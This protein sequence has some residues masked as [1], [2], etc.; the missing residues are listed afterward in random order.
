MYLLVQTR[1]PRRFGRSFLEVRPQLGE[2]GWRGSQNDK[3]QV[4]GAEPFKIR[5]QAA[6]EAGKLLVGGCAAV[7]KP[8][9]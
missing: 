5:Y 4:P 7:E 6:P 2:T 3:A 1:W 8:K 9:Q